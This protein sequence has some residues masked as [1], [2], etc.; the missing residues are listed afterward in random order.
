MRDL[1]NFSAKQNFDF[2]VNSPSPKNFLPPRPATLADLPEILDLADE[3][4]RHDRQFD[5]S[6]DS[7][8]NR[9]PE[10]TAWYKDS[11]EDKDACVLVAENAAGKLAGILVGRMDEP[12]PWRAVGGMLAELEFLCVSPEA[13]SGGIGG[14]LTRAFSDWARSRNAKRIWV[15]VSAGNTAGVRFY[16]REG[17]GDYDTILERIL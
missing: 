12:A 14:A 11:I 6:L 8:Y 13:R 3:L 15:R 7:G 4:F 2:S 16:K 17:F 9:S 5:P 1:S 10:G